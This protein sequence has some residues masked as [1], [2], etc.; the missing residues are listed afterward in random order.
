ML[1]PSSRTRTA[2]YRSRLRTLGLRQVQIWVPD[3]T[4]PGFAAEARRQCEESNRI[5]R[6]ERMMDWVEDVSSFDDDAP[7]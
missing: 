7:R 3:T 2:R 4:R 1:P 5:E 6:E